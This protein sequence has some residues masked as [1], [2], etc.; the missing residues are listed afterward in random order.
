MLTY[1]HMFCNPYSASVPYPIHHPRQGLQR[2]R[3]PS[4]EGWGFWTHELVREH[5]DG[6][7]P[8]A[9][10]ARHL[11]GDEYPAL[12]PRLPLLL[13]PGLPMQLVPCQRA[14]SH[15]SRAPRWLSISG[16]RTTDRAFRRWSVPAD[17]RT[18]PRDSLLSVPAQVDVYRGAS[19]GCSMLVLVRMQ[20]V[21]GV[22]RRTY[23]RHPHVPTGDTSRTYW[24]HPTYLLETKSRRTSS[25]GKNCGLMDFTETL[26]M[27]PQT[28]RGVWVKMADAM[29]GHLA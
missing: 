14:L 21:H 19:D 20:G 23:W 1:F 24:R 11:P 12:L 18:S 3:P 5:A 10:A 8:L 7:T 16:G 9:A 15:A 27:T 17:R 13:A 4:W 2:P 28:T 29:G 6:L 26:E 22:G 25:V